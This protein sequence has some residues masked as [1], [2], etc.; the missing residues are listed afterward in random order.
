MREI[1]LIMDE[2]MLFNSD[3]AYKDYLAKK[4]SHP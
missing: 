4:A 2:I 1:E 3:T